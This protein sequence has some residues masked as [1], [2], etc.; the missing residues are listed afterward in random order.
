MKETLPE[1]LNRLDLANPGDQCDGMTRRVS[2]HLMSMTI[3]HKVV[4]G[5]LEMLSNLPDE[6]I[7]PAVFDGNGN[8]FKVKPEANIFHIWVELPD[9]QIIDLRA[10]MWFGP[11]AP[12]GLFDP[13]DH[14]NFRYIE[15]TR[16]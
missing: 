1:L 9:K 12:H 11:T 10:R 14:P 2:N 3:S 8:P 16:R 5:R 6:I 4:I 13:K 15:R 7:L